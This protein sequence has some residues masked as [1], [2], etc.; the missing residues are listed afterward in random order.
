[1]PVAASREGVGA[2]AGW[3]G[4][5]P[6]VWVWLPAGDVWGTVAAGG[7]VVAAV[8]TGAVA[9]PP[10]FRCSLAAFFCSYAALRA[11]RSR[12]RFSFFDSLAGRVSRGGSAGTAACP[13]WGVLR[14]QAAATW[15]RAASEGSC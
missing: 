3:P 9:E 12:S 15:A 11:A 4:R 2:P 8:A 7:A 6:G 5:F 10:L 13:A 14:T 1:M